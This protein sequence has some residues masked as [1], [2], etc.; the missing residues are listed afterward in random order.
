M[1]FVN[2][3]LKITIEVL[4]IC[5]TEEL[6]YYENH[7]IELL[8]TMSPNG[9]NLISGKTNCRQSEE[10]KQ[11]KRD[12]MIGKNV[13]RVMEKRVRIREEDSDLPKY[14]RSYRDASG[15]E[16]FRICNHP[17]LKDRSF[18]SKY[19]SSDDKLKLALEYLKTA[20]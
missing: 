18:V 11:L 14:I 8:N 17:T 16:G 19:V 5:K 15:K 1:L 12:S 9:Y 2:T 4:K 6:N 13:G 7:Y 20:D 3:L 10:T